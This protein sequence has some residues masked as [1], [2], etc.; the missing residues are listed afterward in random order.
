MPTIYE[1]GHIKNVANLEDLISFCTGYGATFNP[2]KASIQLAALNALLTSCKAAIDDVR[3]K[4]TDFNN[5]TNARQLAFANLKTLA[6]KLI[7]ALAATDALDTTIDD[8]KSI[9]RKIQGKRA[10][11]KKTPTFSD[12]ENPGTPDEKTISSSQQSYDQMTEH[13]AKLISL[14]QSE[15]TYTPNEADLQIA[16][17]NAILTNMTTTNTAVINAYTALSNSR[18]KRNDL[19]YKKNTGLH[20]IAQEVKMYIKSIFGATSPQYK[21]V[22]G[23]KFSKLT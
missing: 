13:F 11:K 23:I 1:T 10:S 15:P 22:S 7:N 3:A 17:L 21:Q 9:N 18:I 14:L 8:A 16:A 20:D 2:S 5:A 4:V 6:T 12:P 19:L